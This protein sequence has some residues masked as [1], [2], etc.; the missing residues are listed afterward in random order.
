VFEESQNPMRC[1]LT[2]HSGRWA[3]FS[4]LPLGLEVGS[5]VDPFLISIAIIAENVIVMYCKIRVSE[6]FLFSR[7]LTKDG[8]LHAN[9]GGESG[10]VSCKTPMQCWIWRGE[11]GGEQ[12]VRI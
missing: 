11:G 5:F 3:P 6:C 4:F 2:W 1:A 12:A 10:R 9:R 8:K 7:S